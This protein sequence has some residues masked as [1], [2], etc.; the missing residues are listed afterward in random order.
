METLDG[1]NSRT[2]RIERG[3]RGGEPLK[4]GIENSSGTIKII[5]PSPLIA[6]GV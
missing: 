6:N 3:R 1:V 2:E 5:F 4:T